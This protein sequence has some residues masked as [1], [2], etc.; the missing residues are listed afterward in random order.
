MSDDPTLPPHQPNTLRTWL[1]RVGAWLWAHPYVCSHAG[2][3][4][5]GGLVG[6]ALGHS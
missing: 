5:L 6:Y 4:L 1:P 2:F 3:F